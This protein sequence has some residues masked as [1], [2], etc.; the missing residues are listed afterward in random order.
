[1]KLKNINE[2]LQSELLPCKNSMSILDQE[3]I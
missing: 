1:V 2:I 3:T